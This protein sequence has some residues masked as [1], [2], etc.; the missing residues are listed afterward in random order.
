MSTV[1]EDNPSEVMNIIISGSQ[2]RSAAMAA[3]KAA[4]AHDFPAAATCLSN[5]Q[6]A[7][8]R[9]QAAHNALLSAEARG[10]GADF[11]VLLVHAENHLSNA[12]TIIDTATQ[13]VDTYHELAALNARLDG[14]QK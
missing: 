8:K 11:S 13:F 4:K 5:A 9:A 1:P 10:D 14:L 3:I 7:V 2:A 6:V 12:L